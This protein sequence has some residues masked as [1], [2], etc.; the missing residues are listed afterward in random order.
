MRFLT[1]LRPLSLPLI[2]ALAS[3]SPKTVGIP[4]SLDKPVVS[5][6]GDTRA[7]YQDGDSSHSITL[8]A[9]GTYNFES[10]GPYGEGLSSRSGTWRWRSQ[11]THNAELTLDSD[12]W[13]LSFIDPYSAL[14][15]NTAASGRTF[16]FQFERL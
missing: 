3:C 10:S 7:F 4:P 9:D 12:V 2:L 1:L 11:G 16:D 13:T 14:A 5:H 6:P 8:L 15:V